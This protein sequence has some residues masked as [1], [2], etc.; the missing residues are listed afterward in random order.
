MIDLR[1]ISHQY[2]L[3]CALLLSSFSASAATVTTYTDEASY[4]ASIATIPHGST[5]EDFSAVQTNYTMS[6][7]GLGDEWNGFNVLRTGTGEFGNS[8]Y[9]PALSNPF[10]DTP[11]ACLDYN[12]SAP[13]LPGI[14][15]SF[16]SSITSE[17]SVTFT[18]FIDNKI[19]AF[20]FDFVDWNDENIRSEF[21]IN[22]SDGTSFAVSG[23][24]NPRNTPAQFFGFMLDQASINNEIYI[25]NIHWVGF[26]TSELVGLWNIGT[27]FSRDVTAVP[28]LSEW[29]LILLA[30]LLAIVGL[31][32]TR[33]L[34][35]KMLR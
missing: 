35:Q 12:I 3:V 6:D 11:T 23:S 4:N 33:R 34:P 30:L 10:T 29:M 17:S 31:K 24:V 18:P 19:F 22:M 14:S 21:V 26:N 15:A 5:L 25:T 7:A 13:N 16:D 27:K 1:R 32:E 8:G 20:H 28:T 2:T 9:C